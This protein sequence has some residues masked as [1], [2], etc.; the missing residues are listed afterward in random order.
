MKQQILFHA[1]PSPIKKPWAAGIPDWVIQATQAQPTRISATARLE[2]C[3]RC[4]QPTLHALDAGHDNCDTTRIDLTLL[5]N[6]DELQALVNG[7][8]THELITRITGISLHIRNS[9]RIS[10]NP[11]N[12]STTPV[13]PSHQC[14]QILGYPI[15]WNLIYTQPK[16]TNHEPPF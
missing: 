9:S 15:P 5:T 11:A 4:Q 2:P 12:T 7:R 10:W 1:T 3:P 6:T 14:G 16:G 13:A 8:T